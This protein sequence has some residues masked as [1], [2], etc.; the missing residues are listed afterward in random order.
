VVVGQ[1]G[2]TRRRS[3]PVR[4]RTGIVTTPQAGRRQFVVAEAFRVAKEGVV[5]GVFRYF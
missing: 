3:L 4:S 2:A 5:V 1:A